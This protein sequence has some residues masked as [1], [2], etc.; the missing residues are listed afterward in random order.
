MFSNSNKAL[1]FT[2]YFNAARYWHHLRYSGMLE[3]GT[4]RPQ[5]KICGMKI[6]GA[7]WMAVS[8]DVTAHARKTAKEQEAIARSLK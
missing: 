2:L 1:I 8:A 5:N 4:K 7:N 6:N 3:T